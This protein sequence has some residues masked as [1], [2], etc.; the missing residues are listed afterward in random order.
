MSESITAHQRRVL[1]V[2]AG[3]AGLATALRLRALNPLLHITM[4]EATS[5]TGGK[6]VGEI[7]DGCVVDGAA[8]VCIG[9]KLRHTHMFIALGIANRV[10]PANPNSLPTYEWTGTQLKRFATSFDGEL[11]SFRGGM[12][13]LVDIATVALND[14]TLMLDQTVNRVTPTDSDWTI[15]FTDAAPVRSDAII[16]ATPAAAAADLLSDV[17]PREAAMLR[18]LTYPSTTTVTMAWRN[19]DVPRKLD[20]TGYLTSDSTA[21]VSAC[22]WISSKHPSHAAPGTSLLRGYVR[23]DAGSAVALMRSEVATVLGITAAPVFARVN[24]WEAGIPIYTEVHRANVS[25]LRERLSS[26]SGLFVAGAAFDGVGIPDC[27][28]SGERA[29]ADAAQYIG[30]LRTEAAA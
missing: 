3:I 17:A 12:R 18:T 1:V 15:E 28:L 22:T 20:G 27:I 23:G 14:I 2:G 19:S 6:I 11:L 16:I 13:E 5:F 29:A 8:D 21:A 7:V 9:D 30:T 26:V 4:V 25:A 10:I 24:A